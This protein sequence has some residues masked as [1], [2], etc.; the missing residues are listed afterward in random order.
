MIKHKH[1]DIINDA[2]KNANG[3]LA[4]DMAEEYYKKYRAVIAAAEIEC[5]LPEAPLINGQK[6]K[7]RMKKS[8]SRNLL[9]RLSKFEQDVLRFMKE[10]DVP[11]SNNLAENNIRM[12]KVQQKI[13]GCFR[14]MEGAYIF[15]RI[16]SYISTC[17]KHDI[18]VTEALKM[19]F[20]GEMPDF[21]QNTS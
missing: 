15:S 8:K 16:R 11:F 7:G 6:K 12:T 13:S 10:V 3:E 1:P 2:T 9:E 4:E 20:R 14:S 21:M 5:P 19:L 18:A 17:K